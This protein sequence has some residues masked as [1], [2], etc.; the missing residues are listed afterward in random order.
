MTFSPWWTWTNCSSIHQK[1]NFFLLAQNNNISN[2]LILKTYLSVMIS[3]QFLCSQSWLHL[4]L[5]HVFFWSNQL[6]IQILSFSYPR[7]PSNLSS[8]YLD[9]DSC[10]FFTSYPIEWHGPILDTGLWKFII[11]GIIIYYLWICS[12]SSFSSLFNNASA[13]SGV[14]SFK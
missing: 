5:W 7:H 14:F 2:F 1:L 8:V 9:F 3:S 11:I 4:W 10:Y 13:P 6:C 12:S